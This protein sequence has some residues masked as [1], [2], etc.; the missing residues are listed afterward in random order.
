MHQPSR[1]RNRGAT[2]IVIAAL[3]GW[4]G[5]LVGT[6]QV[7]AS[8]CYFL[9][10]WRAHLESVT[11][12]DPSVD[13]TPFWG[14]EAYFSYYFGTVCENATS[15]CTDIRSMEM[16]QSRGPVGPVPPGGVRSLKAE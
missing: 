6:S 10:T 2:Y 15:A 12:S 11:S 1:V 3:G 5:L 4:C 13:H 8:G 14:R 16:N 7:E 9:P